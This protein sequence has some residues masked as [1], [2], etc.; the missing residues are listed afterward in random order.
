MDL[1]PD[2]F[3]ETLPLFPLDGALLLPGGQMPLHI[4][5]ERY[6]D[7]IEDALKDPYRMV[8]MVMPREKTPLFGKKF[9]LLVL[10]TRRGSFYASL[11][12]P[13]KKT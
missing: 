11:L 6:V 8:G 12:T 2:Y 13:H 10:I 1:N 3:P 5:E 7:M 4:F 9:I